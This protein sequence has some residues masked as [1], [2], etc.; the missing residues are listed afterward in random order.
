MIFTDWKEADEVNTSCSKQKA[1]GSMFK[2]RQQ[3]KAANVTAKCKILFHMGDSKKHL[4]GYLKTHEAKIL[5]KY[6]M[7]DQSK[8]SKS[9]SDLEPKNIFL[10]EMNL[11][12]F[13]WSIENEEKYF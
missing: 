12:L 6:Q 5:Y 11:C 13:E 8:F 4:Y 9:L 2:G 7:Y 1:I 3:L 10:S